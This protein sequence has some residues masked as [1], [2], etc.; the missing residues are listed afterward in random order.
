VYL[1]VTA[2]VIMGF[3]FGFVFG[4]LDVEDEKLANLRVALQREERCVAFAGGTAGPL[5]SARQHLLPDRRGHR[6][7]RCCCEPVAAGAERLDA[8]RPL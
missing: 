4:L 8:L 5:T 1:V 7:T 2:A 3:A 6:R